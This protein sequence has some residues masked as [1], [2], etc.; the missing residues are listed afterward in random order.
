MWNEC[1]LSTH[2]NPYD[3]FTQF[4]E[5]LAFDIEKG[6]DSCSRLARIAKISDDMTQKEVD[7]AI[8]AAIDEIIMYDFTNTYTKVK[9]KAPELTTN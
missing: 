9:R 8:E 5:W 1:M 7:E 2:D 4:D 6:Y 3:Y